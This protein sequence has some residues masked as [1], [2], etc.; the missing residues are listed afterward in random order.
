MSDENDCRKD[1]QEEKQEHEADVE[2]KA[3]GAVVSHVN[4]D[5]KLTQKDFDMASQKLRRQPIAVSADCK[6]FLDRF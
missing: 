2:H 3:T 1:F 5:N 4:N 6:S